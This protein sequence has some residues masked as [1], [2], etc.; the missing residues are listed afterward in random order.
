MSNKQLG[1]SHGDETSYVLKID[2]LPVHDNEEDT[3][4]IKIM[5]NIWETFIK[6]G[7]VYRF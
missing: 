3:K 2:Y 1:A 4:M 5:V 6:N 7:S